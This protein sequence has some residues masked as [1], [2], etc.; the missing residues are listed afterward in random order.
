MSHVYEKA[1]TKV[2][3]W[4]HLAERDLLG[5]TIATFNGEAGT[6]RHLAL[7]DHHGICFSFEEPPPVQN[8]HTQKFYPVSTIKLYGPLEGKA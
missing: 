7:D 2:M 6:V 1:A 4:L 3:E 5:R 8:G